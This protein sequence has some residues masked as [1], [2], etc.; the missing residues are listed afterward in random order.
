M[1]DFFTYVAK[2]HL[3]FKSISISNPKQVSVTLYHN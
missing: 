1:D 2:I 3:F